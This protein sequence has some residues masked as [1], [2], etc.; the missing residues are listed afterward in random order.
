[1]TTWLSGWWKSDGDAGSKSGRNNKVSYKLLVD[2]TDSPGP[3]GVGKVRMMTQNRYDDEDAIESGS[4]LE[5]NYRVS[6]E[7]WMLWSRGVWRRNDWIA[8]TRTQRR[9]L[10][11]YGALYA[12]TRKNVIQLLLLFTCCF[13]SVEEC[14]RRTSFITFIRM[15]EWARSEHTKFDGL[16]FSRF[17]TLGPLSQTGKQSQSKKR[18][19][20]RQMKLTLILC[21]RQSVRRAHSTHMRSTDE[22]QCKT[23]ERI[24]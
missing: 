7:F 20:T 24:F 11:K 1:M 10:T 12:N 16:V 18:L 23:N 19:H 2:Q 6:I 13:T 22:I 5:E 15:K 14:V 9:R 4:L 3:F 8:R 21:T 17:P